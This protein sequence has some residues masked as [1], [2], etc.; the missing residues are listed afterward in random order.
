[1][2]TQ[3]LI[4]NYLK[5]H[6]NSSSKEIFEGLYSVISYATVKRYLSKFLRENYITQQ[7]NAK[8]SRYALSPA[9]NFF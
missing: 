3:E 8:N 1:M 7:G 5:N 2:E 9:F 4:L 6:S